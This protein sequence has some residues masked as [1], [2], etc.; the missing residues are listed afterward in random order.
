LPFFLQGR[1]RGKINN[2][3]RTNSFFFPHAVVE[4]T[5]GSLA[6]QSPNRAPL[7]KGV[8]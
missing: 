2:T 7:Q 4:R 6:S 8:S 5:S 1:R 3:E